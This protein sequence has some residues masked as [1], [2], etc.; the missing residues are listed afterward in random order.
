MMV[1]IPSSA[2][3]S[4]ECPVDIYIY[5]YTQFLYPYAFVSSDHLQACR[6]LSCVALVDRRMADRIARELQIPGI[7][8]Y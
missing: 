2:W 6:V 1:L 8:V 5:M 4:L 7:T 3:W